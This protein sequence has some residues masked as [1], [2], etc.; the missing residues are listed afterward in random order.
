MA[1]FVAKLGHDIL[2][3]RIHHR[4]RDIEVVVG[5]KLIE[6]AALHMGAGQ[7]VQFLLELFADHALELLEILQSESLCEFVVNHGLAG[8]LY[9]SDLDRKD[10]SLA[11]EILG[12]VI[13]REGD[14]DIALVARLDA[15]QSILESRD[16]RPRAELDRHTLSSSAIERYSADLASEIQHDEIAHRSLVCLG[17]GLPCFLRRGEGRQL[18]CDHFVFGLDCQPLELQRV[19]LGLG[20]VGQCLEPNLDLGIL[21]RGIGLVELDLGLHRRADLFLAEQAL[22]ALLDRGRQRLLVERLAVHLANEVGGHLAGAETGHLHGRRDALD[23][24]IQPRVDILGG[25]GQRVGPLEAFIFRLDG[26]HVSF[27]AIQ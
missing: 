14:I 24:L 12:L 23:F 2:K 20:H 7:A 9:F 22:D 5:G 25:D 6:Q 19:D 11:L 27:S 15:D 4:R 13:A 3:L 10:R 26:F 17:R 18:R 21:A 8:G 16:Q 1:G